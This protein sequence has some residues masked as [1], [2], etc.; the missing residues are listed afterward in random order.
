MHL[1]SSIIGAH[2]TPDPGLDALLGHGLSSAADPSPGSAGVSEGV[3]LLL[4]AVGQIGDLRME[5]T[6]VE[7]KLEGVR[8]CDSRA[9]RS[10]A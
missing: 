1:A 8:L 4:Y 5:R 3:D 10:P 6:G 2:I 7:S 9:R